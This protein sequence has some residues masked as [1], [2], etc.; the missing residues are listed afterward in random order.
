MVLSRNDAGEFSD[1]ALPV[2]GF[3][4]NAFLDRRGNEF[5]FI[6]AVEFIGNALDLVQVRLGWSGGAFSG[7]ST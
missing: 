7:Q 2:F 6:E 1:N 4:V 3:G 5:N